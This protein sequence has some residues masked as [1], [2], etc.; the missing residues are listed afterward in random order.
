[1]SLLMSR[2]DL[3]FLLYEWLEVEKLTSRERY[4]DH[5]R[6]TFDAAIAL[7]ETIATDHFAPHNK[8]ADA[9]EPTFDGERVHLIPEG[10]KALEIYFG[11]GLMT[12]SLDEDLGGGQLPQVVSSVL[13][14]WFQAAN[15]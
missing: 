15:V 7:A 2:R 3:E 11:S 8:L 14:T 9:N 10:A 5:S 1:M 12:A 4:S 6:E 13:M